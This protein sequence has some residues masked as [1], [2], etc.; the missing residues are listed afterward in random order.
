MLTSI[1]AELYR[2]VNRHAFYSYDGLV[3][4]RHSMLTPLR[5]TI[6]LLA[7]TC[8]ACTSSQVGNNEPQEYKGGLPGDSAE[9]TVEGYPKFRCEIPDFKKDLEFT[10][11]PGDSATTSKAKQLCD[12]ARS[13][14]IAGMYEKAEEM[15]AV[16]GPD[17][18]ELQ[19]ASMDMGQIIDKCNAS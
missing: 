3:G 8:C 11:A 7:A 1:V 14:G 16:K 19:Q 9:M 18:A 5:I 17:S 2:K 12:C 10:G 6:G 15:A 13:N 4:F